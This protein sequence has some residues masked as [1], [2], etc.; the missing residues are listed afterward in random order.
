MVMELATLHKHF[1]VLHE[2]PGVAVLEPQVQG[3]PVIRKF[4]LEGRARVCG[5]PIYKRVEEV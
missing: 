5:S 3:G 4:N 1:P 2:A